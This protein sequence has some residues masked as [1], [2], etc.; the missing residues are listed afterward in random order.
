MSESKS[1]S[2]TEKTGVVVFSRILGTFVEIATIVF[3]VRMLS[4]TDFAIVSMLLLVYET[5][6]Y[7][8]TLGFPDSVF[9][10]FERIAKDA[11]RSFALQT[12]VILLITGFI[13]VIFILLFNAFLPVY[14]SEWTATSVQTAQELMPIMAI[15]ALLEI[16]TWPVN[17]LMLAADR[18]KD[19]GIY[20]ILNGTMT[21]LAMIL[22]LALGYDFAVAIWTLLGYSVIRFLMSL[23][24]MLKILPP[25]TQKLPRRLIKE[26]TWFA[27]PIGL[28]SLVSR[29]NRYADKFIV[30]YFISEEAFAIYMV[31][32]Q[33]IPAVRVI[34]FAVGSVLI[35][36]FVAL[37]LA[38]ERIALMELWRKGVEKVALLVVPVSIL[39]IVIAYEFIVLLFGITYAPAVILFQ[40]YTLIILIRVAH[41]GSIL[42]AFGD[43][44][45]IVLL[46]LNLLISNVILTIPL[47]YY[48]GLIGAVIGTL[49]ANLYNWIVTLRVIGGHLDV[50]WYRV[51]PFTNY[52]K[53]V[54]ISIIAG[55]IVISL[56]FV[57]PIESI[58]LN[59]A[60]KII[61]YLVLFLSIGHLTKIISPK[62]LRD[63]LDWIQL[64]FLFR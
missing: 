47:T 46:S 3:L 53:I 41:Y 18:Q 20:Q 30:S 6:K 12:C 8:A 56:D 5:A 59:L 57:V 15:I 13:S 62:D 61:I 9:Y 31:G 28:S 55:L 21:F 37:N 39:F 60:W 1:T 25:S 16:P 38:K 63:F 54:G 35:S 45:K 58:A 43:T 10:F 48:F 52:F 32:A 49:I 50:P 4:D 2:L 44:K 14:L 64:K 7:F 27:I 34:P 40:I 33:E 24:W 22:P 51:I 42:Q 11:R 36:R 17:N 19:A 26:Q 29:L 23:I